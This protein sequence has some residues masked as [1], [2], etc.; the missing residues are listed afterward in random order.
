VAS[1]TQTFASHATAESGKPTGWAGTPPGPHGFAHQATNVA[2]IVIPFAAFVLA[3]IMLWGQLVEWID[4]AVLALAYVAT[5]LG[6]TV[7]FHRLLTHR[8]FQT[9]PS[10]R[11]AL[12]VLGTLAVEGSVIKWVADHRKHHDFADEDGDPH[13]PHGAGPGVLGALAGL[14][15]AHVGWRVFL[16]HHATFSINS[17]CHFLRPPPLRYQG[18]VHERGLAL[19]RNARG[20]L[21]QQPPRLPDIGISRPPP[22]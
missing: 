22:R 20:V 9:Y 2:A 21:A 3:A 11:Y 12:A 4:L 8:S 19:A 18:P 5:C 7:G 1:N 16:L 15:H 13:S 17:I 6:V 14:W 10:V